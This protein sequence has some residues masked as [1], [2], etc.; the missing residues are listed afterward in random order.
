MLIETTKT[1]T[2]PPAYSEATRTGEPGAASP[3]GGYSPPPITH[4]IP[5][6]HL[7]SPGQFGPTP[8]QN[9]QLPYAY[10]DPHSLHSVQQADS[11]ARWRF[12]RAM[13]WAVG[14][15]CLLGMLIGV[16]VEIATG[17]VGHHASG[18]GRRRQGQGW[19]LGGWWASE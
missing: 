9:L 1:P 10:Y 14:L 5:S 3:Q 15:W 12:I 6:N 13:V 7:M 2:P 4:T 17:G 19:G 18:E 8:A 16:Q 11:R